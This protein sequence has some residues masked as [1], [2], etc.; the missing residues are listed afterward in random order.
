MS[1]TTQA[2]RTE[3][4]REAMV[5]SE[6]RR[7]CDMYLTWCKCHWC[8]G[9]REKANAAIPPVSPAPAL[10]TADAYV[11]F[12]GWNGDVL[13][14]LRHYEA[15]VGRLE[16]EVAEENALVGRAIADR[17]EA[18]AT[19]AREAPFAALGRKWFDDSDRQG[20][21]EALTA[22]RAALAEEKAKEPEWSEAAPSKYRYRVKAGTLYAK[23]ETGVPEVA[24]EVVRVED[25][26]FVAALLKGVTP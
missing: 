7:L 16:R 12:C 1:E 14:T 15:E 17:D 3:A 20:F 5:D 11:G 22:A 4:E 6:A 24:L 8:K 26:A 9:A 25:A 10:V 19:L 21:S 18:R 23:C 13:A 2:P